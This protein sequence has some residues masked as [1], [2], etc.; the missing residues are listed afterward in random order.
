MYSFFCKE[1]GK[2]RIVDLCMICFITLLG[3]AARVLLYPYQSNDYVGF[4]L[5]WTDYMRDNG[6]IGGLTGTF[7]YEYPPL[8]MLFLALLTYLPIPILYGIKILSTVFDIAL[9]VV[10]S[11]FFYDRKRKIIIYSIMTFLPTAIW[12]S[13]AWGQTDSIYVTF[14]LASLYCMTKIKEDGG[15]RYSFWAV[16]WISI[17][18][19]FKLQSIFLLPLVCFFILKSKIKIYYLAMIPGAYLITCLPALIVGRSLRSLLG[20]YFELIGSFSSLLSVGFPNIY[21][22]TSNIFIQYFDKLGIILTFALLIILLYFCYDKKLESKPTNIILLE[23]TI[24]NIMVFFLPHMHER[25]GYFTDVLTILYGIYRPKKMWIAILMIL[26][27]FLAY[28]H[29]FTIITISLELLAFLRGISMVVLGIDLY[30][31]LSHTVKE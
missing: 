27:S 20:V 9:A 22:I 8:Y 15:G 30:E 7:K 4:F 29:H 24:G 6:G 23:L 25:Y 11:L 2:W 10:S 3:V 13:S 16:F 5:P 18:F 14:L 28:M 31:D 21:T 17:A 12:N 26:T 1:Y 19:C